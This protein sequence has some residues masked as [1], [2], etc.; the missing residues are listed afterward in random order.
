MRF[1]LDVHL[2][3]VLER[4]L[5]EWGHDALHARDVPAGSSLNDPPLAAVADVAGRVMVSKDSDML[6]LH[7][8]TG[9]PARLLWV[10]TGNTSNTVLITAF[11]RH[12]A[13]ALD[14]L[15]DPGVVG[16]S[17]DAAVVL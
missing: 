10:T 16:L 2:P 5:T 9:S 4:K 13:D 17:L 14:P 3:P 15:A 7:R 12:L 8:T 1:L 11:E 6:R